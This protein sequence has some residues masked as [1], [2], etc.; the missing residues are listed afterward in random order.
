[1]MWY[2]YWSHSIYIVAIASTLVPYCLYWIHDINTGGLV[3][4]LLLF[5]FTGAMVTYISV[6]IFTLVLL[7]LYFD[8]V[9]ILVPCFFCLLVP[10]YLYLLCDICIGAMVFKWCHGIFIG[11]MVLTMVL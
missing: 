6:M 8:M 11:A 1:M 4:L 7:Y 9:L 3:L 5:I 10:W 2:L